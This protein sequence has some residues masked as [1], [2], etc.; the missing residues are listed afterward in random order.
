MTPSKV[1][2]IRGLVEVEDDR[3][4]AD[5]HPMPAPRDIADRPQALG[6]TKP[7]VDR[8]TVSLNLHANPL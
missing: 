1:E 3:S 2:S 7:R 5:I 4:R 6:Y 8:N